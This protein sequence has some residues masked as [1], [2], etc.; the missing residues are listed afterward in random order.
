MELDIAIIGGGL[1]GSATALALLNQGQWRVGIFEMSSQPVFRVGES[2]P[3]NNQYLLGQLGV[4]DSFKQQGHLPSLGN[5]SAWGEDT[6]AYNDFWTS[7]NGQGW[8]LDRSR[9]DTW[10]LETAAERGTTVMQGMQVIGCDRTDQNYWNLKVKNQA[11][12]SSE[13]KASFVV[14]ASGP[15]SIFARWQ[16]SNIIRMDS[17]LGIASIFPIEGN[18]TLTTNYTLIEAVEFGWWYAARLPENQVIITLMCD[19]DLVQKYKLSRLENWQKALE[20]TLHVQRLINGVNSSTKLQIFSAF[21]QYLDQS[22]GDNWLA[23]GDAACKLDP[24]S[25]S[26]IYK[27]LSS[28]IDAANAIEKF[29][30]GQKNALSSYHLQNQHQFELYLEDRRQY[31]NQ[32]TR[33]KKSPFWKRRQGHL[34]LSPVTVLSFAPTS[35]NQI[36]L[37][38]LDQHFSPHDLHLLCK[39]CDSPQPASVVVQKFLTQTNKKISAYRPI[40]ALQYLIDQEVIEAA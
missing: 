23:V 33:W 37:K 24:L 22:Y 1:A 3:P 38:K 18:E 13:V 4:L 34:S 6:L 32:E 40:E 16:G 5:C 29:K 11:G 15:R 26:G 30:N 27:A 25:S 12:N 2:L 9:F 31:Y 19:R 10:L 21:S 28:G 8:H 17:L 14:D 35:Q 39:L 36:R 20:Q 7:I